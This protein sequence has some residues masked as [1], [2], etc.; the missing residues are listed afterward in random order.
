MNKISLHT[1]VGKDPST[2]NYTSFCNLF[3]ASCMAVYHVPGKV[4]D[5]ESKRKKKTWFI[6]WPGAHMEISCL[7]CAP[8][9]LDWAPTCAPRLRFGNLMVDE[10]NLATTMF[11]K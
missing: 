3:Q 2:P 8:I 11:C 9:L 7:T 10:P 5:T 6:F 1:S 4:L